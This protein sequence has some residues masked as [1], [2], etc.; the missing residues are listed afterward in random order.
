MKNIL[1]D[2]LAALVAITT[3]LGAFMFLRFAFAVG[4]P[5]LAGTFAIV[6]IGPAVPIPTA[7][8][9]AKV[10]TNKVKLLE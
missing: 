2:N 1:R 7:M 9:I 10:A 5:G 6:L 3:V 4:N 8:A